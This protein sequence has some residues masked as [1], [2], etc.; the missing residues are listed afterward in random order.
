VLGDRAL[1]TRAI[2]NLLGNALKYGGEDGQVVAGV[3]LEGGEAWLTVRDTGP[4]I[5]AED[6]ALVWEPFHRLAPAEGQSAESGAGLG[7]SFVKRVIERHGGRVFAESAPGT[8]SNF[9]FVIPL[10]GASG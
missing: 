9:G 5:A 10:A 8:G 4:G 2:Q 3:R 6:L 1:L 7:L